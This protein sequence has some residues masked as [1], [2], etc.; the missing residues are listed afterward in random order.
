[1]WTIVEEEDS[2]NDSVDNF[3]NDVDALRLTKW[4]SLDIVTYGQALTSSESLGVSHVRLWLR[5]DAHVEEEHEL[6]QYWLCR[7]R[8]WYVLPLGIR[9]PT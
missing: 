3:Q 5:T 1:V 9:P 6:K 2:E 7:D 4:Q 8:E